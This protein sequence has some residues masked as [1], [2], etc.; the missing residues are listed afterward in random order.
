MNVHCL[1][2]MSMLAT[3][4]PGPKPWAQYVQLR[5]ACSSSGAG[6]PYRAISG[7]L[8]GEAAAAQVGVVLKSNN[9]AVLL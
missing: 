3:F 9:A 7:E 1:A 2:L 5:S 4:L 6:R 8:A